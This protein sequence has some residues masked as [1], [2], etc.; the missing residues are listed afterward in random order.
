MTVYMYFFNV[1]TAHLDTAGTSYVTFFLCSDFLWF[2]LPTA[3]L[4]S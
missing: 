3:E 4:S 2:I 1:T